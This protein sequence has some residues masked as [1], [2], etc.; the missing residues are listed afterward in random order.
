LHE[1]TTDYATTGLSLKQHPVA[2]IRD[3]LTGQGVTAAHELRDATRWPHGS[4]ITV[5]GLVFLRQRPASLNS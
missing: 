2:F 4:L 1:V 3:W 5:G